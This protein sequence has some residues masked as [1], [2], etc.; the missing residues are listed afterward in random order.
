MADRRQQLVD[1][2]FSAS[3]H[4]S[5]VNVRFQTKRPLSLSIS[6]IKKSAPSG[7]EESLSLYTRTK[8]RVHRLVSPRRSKI[9]L[10]KKTLSTPNLS[11]KEP[12]AKRANF[13]NQITSDERNFKHVPPFSSDSLYPDSFLLE[14]VGTVK[15]RYAPRSR[16]LPGNK[17]GAIKKS[18]IPKEVEKN[19]EKVAESS[20]ETNN[21]TEEFDQLE[22]IPAE[23][24]QATNAQFINDLEQ[25]FFGRKTSTDTN[26]EKTFWVFGEKFA[27]DIPKENDFFNYLKTTE[28]KSQQSDG[29]LQKQVRFSEKNLLYS[30]PTINLLTDESFSEVKE[31]ARKHAE[32][33]AEGARQSDQT[34]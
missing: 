25:E 14:R 21:L 11:I 4:S 5:P 32:V 23:G 24:D 34:F 20:E 30:P 16:S 15:D 18:F 26:K 31:D 13:S 3:P 6:P 2:N 27:R 22:I 28:E 33:E 7:S 17:S 8:N 9:L 10:S 19:T 1:E 12:A 29:E